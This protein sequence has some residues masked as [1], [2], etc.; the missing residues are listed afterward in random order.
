MGEL[1]GVPVG[2]KLLLGSVGE[3]MTLG[4]RLTMEEPLPLL[5][6]LT[7]LLLRYPWILRSLSTCARPRLLPAKTLLTP[8]FYRRGNANKKRF[9]RLGKLSARFRRTEERAR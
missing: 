5:L 3:E 7:V 1:S 4:V 8:E 2:L 9:T 6:R